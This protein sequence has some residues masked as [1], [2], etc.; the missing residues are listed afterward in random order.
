MEL[1]KKIKKWRNVLKRLSGHGIYPYEMAFLLDNPIRKII[2]PPNKLV[3]R[4]NLK[5]NSGVLEIGSGPGYF[6]IETARRIPNG[7][8][9]SFDIQ[10]EMLIKSK[11]KL[12]KTNLNNVFAVGGNATA[13]PFRNNIFD[14]VFLVTVLGEVSETKKCLTSINHVLRPG[15]TL[16]I[17]EMKG[18][19]DLLNEKEVKEIAIRSGFQLSEK[20]S[21][22]KG[23]TLNFIKIF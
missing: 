14:V 9:F 8:L 3:D 18:D 10:I 4:L 19:P 12:L 13:L 1:F 17:T 22:F 23:Y 6:V 16:S 21:S 11:Q 7:H 5:D 2:L 15:G 20:F